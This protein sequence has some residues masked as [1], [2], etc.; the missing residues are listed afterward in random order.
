MATNNIKLKMFCSMK[1]VVEVDS[2]HFFSPSPPLLP[3]MLG[4]L[5]AQPHNV[6]N[7]SR[8]VS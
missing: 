6:A 8:S 7:S 5:L 3:E 2:R 4:A 1:V